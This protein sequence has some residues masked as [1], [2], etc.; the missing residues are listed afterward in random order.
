[1]KS[2]KRFLTESKVEDFTNRY[3]KIFKDHPLV[4]EN[5]EE[6]KKLF[7]HTHG[8][9]L[10]HH[11][12][13]FT[14]RSFL[15]KTLKP[16][17]DEFSIRQTINKWNKAKKEG[18][19]T[20]E[21]SNHTFETVRS[22]LKKTEKPDT[23]PEKVARSISPGLKNYH[24]GTIEH[25]EH[26]SLNVYHISHKQIGDNMDEY[27]RLSSE[28]KNHAC[29]DNTHCVVGGPY[30]LNNYSRGHGFLLYTGKNNKTIFGHGFG[31]RGI[32]DPANDVVSPEE[33]KFLTQKTHALLPES[34]KDIY[35]FIN[36]DQKD[37]SLEKQEKMYNEFGDSAGAYFAHPKKNTHPKILTKLLNNKNFDVVQATFKHP[38]LPV[39]H[40][41]KGLNDKSENIRASAI[42]NPNATQEHITKALDDK[43]ENVRAYA[44]ERPNATP[45]H[46]SKALGDKTGH[47]R[48]HAIRNPNA[49]QE[50][51]TRALDDIADHVR[52]GAIERP[53]VTPEH[54]SKALDDK[55]GYVRVKAILHPKAT[56]EH[57]SKALGNSNEH[58]RVSAIRN[59]NATQEHI[60]RALDDISDYVRIGAIQHPNATPEHISKALGDSYSIS[61]QAIQ[62][63]NATPEHI[64]KALGSSDGEIRAYAIQH[65]NATPEH[66]SKALDDYHEGVRLSAILHPKATPEHI[67][68]ALGDKSSYVRGTAREI[69]QERN[70]T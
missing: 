34:H 19:V 32:V 8:L 5:P 60:T 11:E 9:G 55:L 53:N 42:R 50:H 25:P 38:N 57:I 66:I 43:S 30:H 4:K 35:H 31:D 37:F 21:I 18:R 47:V 39:E 46:I 15:D 44:I 67:S 2:F 56:P 33:H 16:N 6:A 52:I 10:G 54:I 45:E 23:D 68:K 40:I 58:V 36:S 69:I 70:K 26:G 62:H 61:K 41:T 22:A 51:I 59:P 14:I 64:S 27:S 48:G 65:P 63:P 1:M 29:K 17:E 13:V 20:G 28:L 24:I 7:T 3:S 49:T 12:S